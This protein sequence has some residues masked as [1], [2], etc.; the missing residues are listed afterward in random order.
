MSPIIARPVLAATH[1]AEIALEAS[2]KSRAD[3][4]SVT[5]DFLGRDGE[6][7]HLEEL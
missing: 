3:T 5:L 4:S 1:L 2:D 7:G 6:F